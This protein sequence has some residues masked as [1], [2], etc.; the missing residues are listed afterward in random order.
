MTCLGSKESQ[1]RD[2]ESLVGNR[3]TL[4]SCDWGNLNPSALY[5]VTTNPQESWVL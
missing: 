1:G 3:I 5:K 2:G 4:S